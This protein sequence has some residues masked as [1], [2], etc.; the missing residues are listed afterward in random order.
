[1]RMFCASLAI[2]PARIAV[3]I[4]LLFP[5]R[6]PNFDLVDDVTAGIE[7]LVPVRGRYA[8]PDGTFAD[9]QHA[10]PVY[11]MGMKDRELCPGLCNDF[12]A[13]ADGQGLV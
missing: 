12:L 11:A 5:D 9:F 10:G 1:M 4:V 3:G 13:L 8:D 7:C 2:N 6:Q